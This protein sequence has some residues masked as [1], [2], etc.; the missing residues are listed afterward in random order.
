MLEDVILIR[1]F[2]R[3]NPDALRA[4]YEKYCR[5]MLTVATAL[6]HDVHT[7]EDVVQDCFIS[8]ARTGRDLK[9]K[10][11]LQAYLTT[12]VVNRLRDRWRARKHQPQP[13]D[14][15]DTLCSKESGPET[16]A[17]CNDQMRRVSSAL[18][19]IPS[20]EREAVVLY[21]RGRMTYKEIAKLQGVSIPT[22]R[23][24]Y[25]EGLQKL[26]VFL[27]GEAIT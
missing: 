5:T 10:G 1:K 9:L 19:K 17:L 4:I 25:H 11:S 15:A 21:T 24:R 7:A 22:V 6:C 14:Q 18:M 16:L 23:R 2:K 13:L 20:E 12:S 27:N 3:G 26:R 8:F